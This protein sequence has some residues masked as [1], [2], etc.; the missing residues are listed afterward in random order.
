MLYRRTLRPEMVAHLF[1]R[2]LGCV[3]RARH[4]AASQQI[5]IMP[6]CSQTQP[7]RAAA[8]LVAHLVPSSTTGARSTAQHANN[9]GALFSAA[10]GVGAACATR[11]RKPVSA[12]RAHLLSGAAAQSRQQRRWCLCQEQRAGWQIGGANMKNTGMRT[13]AAEWAR[14]ARATRTRSK[15]WRQTCPA[16][17]SKTSSSTKN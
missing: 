15:D 3:Q 1:R 4:D 11:F 2:Q 13:Y 14:T 9:A 16:R 17:C 6:V 12:R 10:T 8:A 7:C 5:R